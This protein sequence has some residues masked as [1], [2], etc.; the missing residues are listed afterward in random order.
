M[1]NTWNGPLEKIDDYRWRI[2]AS[3]DTGMKTDGLIYADETL[4]RQVRSD[5]APQQVANVAHLPGIAGCSMAMPDIHWGYGFPIGGVAAMD[6]EEGVVSP[7]GVGYDINCGVRLVKTNLHASEIKSKVRQLVETLFQNVPCG[8]GSSGKLKLTGRQQKEVLRDG[9]AWAV[10]NGFG[11]QSDIERAEQGGCL[12]GA[13]ADALSARALERGKPQLGTLGSGN[14]FLEIQ[15]VTH[16]F[17]PAAAESYGLFKGQAVI[18][19][20]TGSRGL[21]YQVCDDSID[22]MIKAMRKYD[23]RIPDQQLACAAPCRGAGVRCTG[24]A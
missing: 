22:L 16:I 4:L 6:V 20:H 5:Q 9:A 18:M 12:E 21:G 13:D 19:I 1:S 23:I 3:Y 7:G 24:D 11:W 17:N 8:V 10:K 2:P 14:H 15:E